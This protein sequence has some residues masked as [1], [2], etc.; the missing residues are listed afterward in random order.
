MLRSQQSAVLTNAAVV[1]FYSDLDRMY[2]EVYRRT[3]ECP[4]SLRS[5]RV[6]RFIEQCE[7]RGV[8]VDE[9]KN[10]ECVRAYRNIGNGSMVM[11]Q[12]NLAQLGSIVQLFPQ[13]GQRS[14]LRDTV[15]ALTNVDTADRYVPLDT[16]QEIT[17]DHS[18]AMLENDSLAHGSPVAFSPDQN[19]VVHAQIHMQAAAQGLESVQFGAQPETVLA[20]LDR[21]MPHDNAHI[22]ALEGNPQRK[23]EAKMLREQWKQIAKMADD[24]RKAAG[25]IM[26]KRAEMAEA[27]RKAQAIQDGQDPETVIKAAETQQKLQMSWQRA[28]AK[29]QMDMERLKADIALQGRRQQAEMAMRDAETAASITRSNAETMASIERQDKESAAKVK[30]GAKAESVEGASKP[31]PK[32]SP[33]TLNIS[34]SADDKPKKGKKKFKVNRDAKGKITEIVAEE[35][36]NEQSNQ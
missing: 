28:Q 18:L 22:T 21:L 4:A 34:V 11:R 5:D 29:M 8:T 12:Q 30:A 35:R 26:Q 2:T 1:R 7:M 17:L 10:W 27:Q 14:W 9:L 20:A 6:R 31:A 13:S 23:N 36:E 15:S 19:H 16:A 3:V 33:P 32:Q 25:E 24:L